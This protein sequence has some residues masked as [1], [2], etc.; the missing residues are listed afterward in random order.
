MPELIQDGET[1][2]QYE[3]GN[4]KDLADKIQYVYEHPEEKARLGSAA[5]AWATDRF[6]QKRYAEEVFDLLDEVLTKPKPG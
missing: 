3:F 2:L 1:G 5:R 6:T 4:H